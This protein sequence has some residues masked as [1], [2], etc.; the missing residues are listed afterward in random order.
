[1]STGWK[2]SRIG[3]V[4]VLCAT[5]CLGVVNPATGATTQTH[6]KAKKPVP[7]P[8]LPSGPTGPVQ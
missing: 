7:L 6:R 4:L 5:V 2:F 8:P 3:G 1:M